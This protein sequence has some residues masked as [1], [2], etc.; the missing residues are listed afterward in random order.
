MRRL[1]NM[2]SASYKGRVLLIR[3]H[4]LAYVSD[5]GALLDKKGLKY[6]VECRGL[7]QS[8]NFYTIGDD[9]QLKSTVAYAARSYNTKFRKVVSTVGVKWKKFLGTLD[10]QWC[11]HVLTAC[12]LPEFYDLVKEYHATEPIPIPD[13]KKTMHARRLPTYP[14]ESTMGGRYVPIVPYCVEP[15]SDDDGVEL[16]NNEQRNTICFCKYR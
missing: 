16:I 4:D 1:R 8:T 14:G 2:P 7:E 3:I 9:G 10:E 6:Y 13:C 11:D 5:F 15:I 12:T